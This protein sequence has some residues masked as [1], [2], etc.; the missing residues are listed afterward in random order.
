MVAYESGTAGDQ[1]GLDIV[2]SRW[3]VHRLVR[4]C[5]GDECD[6]GWHFRGGVLVPS[7]MQCGGDAAV[8][9]ALL[10][11]GEEGPADLVNRVVQPVANRP[12]LGLVSTSAGSRGRNV[13]PPAG[14]GFD[15][16]PAECRSGRSVVP[17]GFSA[18][19]VL[20]VSPCG[21]TSDR[22]QFERG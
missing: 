3:T 2:V 7:G 1:V 6:R 10:A 5:T 8:A 11:A 17:V 4:D 15:P 19:G 14:L 16:K 13:R 20:S 12:T 22:S 9:Q 21:S 18:C